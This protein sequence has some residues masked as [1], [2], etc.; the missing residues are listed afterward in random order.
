MV[1]FSMSEV[2]HTTKVSGE[3]FSSFALQT[4]T[5]SL[6]HLGAQEVARDARDALLEMRLTELKQLLGALLT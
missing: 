1:W 2:Y 3:I 4:D 6:E 5:N